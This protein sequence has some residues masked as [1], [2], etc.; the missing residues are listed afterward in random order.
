MVYIVSRCHGY[1]VKAQQEE[2]WASSVDILKDFL[3]T[4]VRERYGYGGSHADLADQS[5]PSEPSGD[6]GDIA[7]S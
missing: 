7:T 6:P 1:S 4:A 2:L 3:S 5:D